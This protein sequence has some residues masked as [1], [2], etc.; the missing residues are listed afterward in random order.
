M[1]IWLPVIYLTYIYEDHPVN[2]PTIAFSLKPQENV[3]QTH[4]SESMQLKDIRLDKKYPFVYKFTVRVGP[5]TVAI[6]LSHLD[7]S[8]C[9]CCFF[10]LIFYFPIWCT[11]G[12]KNVTVEHE[13]IVGA[14]QSV[15][16][17]CEAEG[18]PPPTYTWTPC[19]PGQVCNKNTLEISQVL[20]GANYTCRVANVHGNDSKTAAV[21]K[22]HVH[23]S[24]ASNSYTSSYMYQH[25]ILIGFSELNQPIITMYMRS[26]DYFIACKM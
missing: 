25:D 9:R 20:N 22:S 26:I 16:L 23:C 11:D 13:V 1:K 7:V 18:N 8:L 15:T 5:L 6:E 17:N 4:I 24:H 14:Q 12:P 10:N 19:D 21:C 2:I 3:L